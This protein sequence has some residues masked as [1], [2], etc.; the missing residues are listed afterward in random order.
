MQES[1]QTRLSESIPQI[2]PIPYQGHEWYM[3]QKIGWYND[4]IG[5]LPDVDCSKCKNK[6]YIAELTDE[7]DEKYIEC[8]C[9][10]KRRCIK[11]IKQSG[12]ERLLSVNC[13]ENYTT[14]FDWQ[15]NAKRRAM[16]YVNNGGDKWLFVAGQSGSGKT[17]LCTAVCGKLLDSGAIVKYVIWRNLLHEL[18]GLQFKDEEYQVKMKELQ[19]VEVLY[20]DDFLKTLDTQKIGTDLNFAFEVINARYI[21]GK[22]TIISTELFSDDILKLDSATFGRINE[23]ASGYLI[24]IKKEDGRNYRMKGASR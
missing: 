9:M 12:L 10:P 21:S 15:A 18:Q 2:K 13:F 19:T 1:L 22:R 5:D 14:E 4:R 17:H 23:K 16:D 20:I 24:Q 3:R 6:G 11:A 8:E 7:L